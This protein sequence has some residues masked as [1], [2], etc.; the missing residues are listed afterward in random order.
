V[1]R[2]IP[3]EN[4][5]GGAGGSLWGGQWLTGWDNR[6]NQKHGDAHMKDVFQIDRSEAWN[7]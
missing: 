5:E 7:G 6:C 1:V 4:T 3:E 2:G